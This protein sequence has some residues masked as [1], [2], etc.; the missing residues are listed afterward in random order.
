M[1]PIIAT[2]LIGAGSSILSKGLNALFDR[3][4]KKDET[5]GAQGAFGITGQNMPGTGPKDPTSGVQDLFK[6]IDT[7][8]DGSVTKGELKTYMEQQKQALQAQLMQIQAE[9]G[10]HRAHGKQGKDGKDTNG[11]ID[12]LF[13]RIDRD[14][15]GKMS[16]DELSNWLKGMAQRLRDSSATVAADTATTSST[17]QV[18]ST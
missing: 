5:D 14:G 12:Q 7:D 4:G 17:T 8:N 9:H 1:T 6:A 2:S 3:V 15:D 16:S 18:S 10:N 13:T 11:R